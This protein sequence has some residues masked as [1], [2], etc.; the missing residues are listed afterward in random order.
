MINEF[1]KPFTKTFKPICF[2]TKS[3]SVDIKRKADLRS[4]FES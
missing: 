4:A 1:I 2:Y 3:F